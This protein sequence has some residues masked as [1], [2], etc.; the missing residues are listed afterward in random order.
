[1]RLTRISWGELQS[2]LKTPHDCDA[3]S[4][5]RLVEK[6]AALRKPNGP[7]VLLNVAFRRAKGDIQ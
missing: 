4:T 2:G 6:V 5:Q 1:L 7:R 3:G